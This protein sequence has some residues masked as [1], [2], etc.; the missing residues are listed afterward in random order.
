MMPDNTTDTVRSALDA[1]DALADSCDDIE[2]WAQSHDMAFP[3]MYGSLDAYRAAALAAT[4]SPEPT[5][6]PTCAHN[7][8][9]ELGT[10]DDPCDGC[11]DGSHY[12]EA[13]CKSCRSWAVSPAMEPCRTCGIEHMRT[14]TYPAWHATTPDTTD[15][16]M[17]EALSSLVWLHAAYR[18]DTA[19]QYVK[20]QEAATALA[21][22]A[23]LT[24]T[25]ARV[26]ELV[27]LGDRMA[28]ILSHS[29]GANELTLKWMRAAALATEEAGR[30]E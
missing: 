13:G 29:A 5:T 28:G 25:H 24:T 26:T 11:T 6:C 19:E 2:K 1:A 3:S 9:P 23:A 30:H 18:P 10:H 20:H 16:R 7:D 4:T 21:A 27:D 8:S 17:S 12:V 15:G 22:L 14:G